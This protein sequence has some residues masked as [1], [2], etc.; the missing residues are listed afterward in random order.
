MNSMISR[1]SQIKMMESSVTNTEKYMGQF[2]AILAAYTRKTARLRDKADLLV[3]QLSDF[4]NTEEQE[5]R[6]CLKNLAEDLAMVQDYRQ[7]EVERLEM[8]VV[9]PLK[10]YGD[11]IKNKRADIKKFNSERNRE[12]KEVQ[13]LDRIRLKNPSDRQGISQAESNALKASTNMSRSTRQLEETM[14]EFQRQKL[15][16]VKGIFS[17]F[18]TV[19]MLFHAKALEVYSSTFQSLQSLD[20][21]KDLEMF[22]KRF[23]MYDNS[24]D[25]QTLQSVRFTSSMPRYPSPTPSS[26][27]PTA[28]Y[29]R[30]ARSS[31]LRRQQEVDEEEEEEDEE[32]YES[33]EDEEERELRSTRESYASEYVRARRLQK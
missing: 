33:E 31:T 16:D 8:R 30:K 32:E 2:C 5:L 24:V 19:E 6:A 11:I 21:E 13:K 27:R 10:A 7:A 23:Q 1:D 18:L 9:T 28:D 22:S 26:L 4:A 14:I 25:N 17:D 15:E 20:I 3:Q 29:P 12:L